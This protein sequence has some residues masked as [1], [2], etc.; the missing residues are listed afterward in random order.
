MRESDAHKPDD[1]VLFSKQA[2]DIVFCHLNYDVKNKLEKLESKN[3]DLSNFPEWSCWIPEVAFEISASEVVFHSHLNRE[4]LNIIVSQVEAQQPYH[5]ISGQKNAKH[6]VDKST[7]LHDVATLKGHIKQGNVYQGNYCI[8]FCWDDIK[9]STAAL[10]VRG[11]SQMPNPFAVYFKTESHALMSFSP[12]RFVCVEGDTI[13]SQ[14]MKGTAPR[15]NTP[16]ADEGFLMA[17]RNSEKDRRENVMI[18]DMVRNDLSH[19]AQRGSVKVPELYK[20]ETYPRVHQMISTVTAKLKPGTPALQAI[21]KAF[22]MA[23]MTGAPKIR[24]MQ[25]LDE[26][27]HAKRGIYS[28]TV[29]FLLPDG[30]A[31]FNVVIRSLVYNAQSSTLTCH[32]GGGITDLSDPEAEY[33]E[34]MLKVKPL[35]E[36]MSGFGTQ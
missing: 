14:P 2:N 9:L 20:I 4:A 30:T 31:D 6:L 28:G 16:E 22:P 23:S 17:L 8:P 21:L 24:A 19:F 26:L 34:C 29:G 36:L 5:A 27:E 33:E 7:Y 1:L 25:I 12:E 32:A 35:L 10:F 18:V 3:L 13:T 15:G 11:F